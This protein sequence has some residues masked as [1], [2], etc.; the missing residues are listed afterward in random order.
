MTKNKEH[1]IGIL[2][3]IIIET[4]KEKYHLDTIVEYGN[5]IVDP[6]DNYNKLYYPKDDITKSKKYTRWISKDKILRTQMTS[7]IPNILSNIKDEKLI[8]C[9]GIVYRRDVVDRTHVGEPHQMDIW[10]ASDKR[11][12]DR[13][14][15]LELVNTI[16][17][18]ISPNVEWRYNETSHHYTKDG[19]EVEI[20]V[21]NKWIEILECG[22]I[23]P[24]LIKD[25]GLDSKWNG[26]ALGMGLDRA[27]MIKKGIDDIRILR[28]KNINIS[29]QMK[30]LDRYSPVSK[31]QKVKRD[32]SISIDK[33]TDVECLG[34]IVRNSIDCSMI[35]EIYIKTE[36]KYEDLPN[37]VSE[38][39]GMDE[40]MKN[41]LLGIT[42]CSLDHQI[43]DIEANEIYK[44]LYKK[45]HKGN[46][47]Y[48]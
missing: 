20:L 30:N 33:E 2:T 15:L 40:S 9:P 38:R 37:H 27:V 42:L 10:I 34:D 1:S 44:E 22:L 46:K 16:V 32:L 45:I 24:K 11:I 14:S 47:G 18:I 6:N 41:V 8:I 36:T 13:N 21:D 12:H 29:K 17:N 3:N 43:T 5:P 4:L 23:N 7:L 26:L 39:L 19:I 28:S 25:S 35:E 31:Y 48:I